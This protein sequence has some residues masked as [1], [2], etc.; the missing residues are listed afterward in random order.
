M[1]RSIDPSP[2]VSGETYAVSA[3]L[4]SNLWRF[5]QVAGNYGLSH[6]ENRDLQNLMG[7]VAGEALIVVDLSKD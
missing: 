3:A 7:I 5:A 4:L 2:F 6:G 1:A